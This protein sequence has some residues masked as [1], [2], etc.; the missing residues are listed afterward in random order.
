[1]NQESTGNPP[2]ES[3][4]DDPMVDALEGDGSSG[5]MDAVYRK[6]RVARDKLNAV[7]ED[8][9]V[10]AD[11]VE[12]AMRKNLAHTEDKIRENPLASVGIAAGVGLL[13]GLLLN[14]RN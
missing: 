3:N 12:K 4:F 7:V 11:H 1:M 6:A 10:R 8:L 14:R 2:L 5:K 13:I 9:G